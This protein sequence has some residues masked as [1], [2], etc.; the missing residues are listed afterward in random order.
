M[1]A[2]MWHG[3]TPVDKADAYLEFLKQRAIPDYESVPG[4]LSVHIMRDI[5]GDQAHFITLTFW[6]S[7]AAIRQFAGDDIL[8]AKY[9]P[10]DHDFLIEFEPMVKHYEVYP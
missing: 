10:E 7:E 6:E 2:R 5:Q 4:N 8:R 3:I 9:Y 1:I